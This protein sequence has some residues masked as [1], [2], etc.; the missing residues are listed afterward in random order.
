MIHPASAHL[1]Q[2]LF[3]AP[4]MSKKHFESLAKYIRVIMD[5]H[6]RLQAAV[7][8]ANACSES[9]PRFDT[10]RFFDACGVQ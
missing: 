5:P 4:N 2:N 3:G 7:A 8:V 6:A 10:Q 1:V 9:N